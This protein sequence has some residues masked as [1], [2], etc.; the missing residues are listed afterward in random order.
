[1]MI[2]EQPGVNIAF[3]QRRLNGSQIHGQTSIVNKGM[4]L[5]EFSRLL[6]AHAESGPRKNL[7]Y[8]RCTP[9]ISGASDAHE[10]LSPLVL[11]IYRQTLPYRAPIYF[12]FDHAL[13]PRLMYCSMFGCG[14]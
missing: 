14:G 5:G 12:S 7:P 9:L 10:F 13:A 11:R 3:A 2:T 6:S 4:S 8:G 1:V